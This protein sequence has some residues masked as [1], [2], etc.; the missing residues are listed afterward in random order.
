MREKTSAR[1][2]LKRKEDKLKMIVVL[3]EDAVLVAPEQR[4][5]KPYVA[6]IKVS[7]QSR[8]YLVPIVDLFPAKIENKRHVAAGS[9][10][11]FVSFYALIKA[12]S[13]MT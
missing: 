8:L 3:Q 11:F 4:G 7:N 9:K 5:E 10:D 12:F 13:H 6:I 2:N 1:M